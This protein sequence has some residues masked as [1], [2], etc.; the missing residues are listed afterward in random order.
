VHRTSDFDL[1]PIPQ[2]ALGEEDHDGF[3][4]L[5]DQAAED[6][7]QTVEML[8]ASWEHGDHDPLI[9]ALIRAR[10]AKEEAEE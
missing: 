3:L 4:A 2:P 10:R 7:E 8:R 5:R 9:F 6:Q 1:H